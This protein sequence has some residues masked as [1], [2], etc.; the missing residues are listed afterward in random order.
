MN[1]IYKL[2]EKIYI[3]AEHKNHDRRTMISENRISNL[4]IINI[5]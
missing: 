1:P 3:I 5:N 2:S 4:I